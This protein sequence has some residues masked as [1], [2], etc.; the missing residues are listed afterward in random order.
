MPVVGNLLSK[1]K[2]RKVSALLA[3]VG[4]VT[5]LV[6]LHKFYLRQPL[7]GIL[8]VLLFATPIPHVASAIEAFWYLAQEPEN[9]D[10]RFN[11]GVAS[12][13]ALASKDSASIDPNRVGATADALRQLEQL[14]QEGLIS[15]YEFEQKRRQLL[16]DIA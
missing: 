15:E 12:D 13:S 5:P 2:N 9:F 14:R 11:F 16:D 3:L 8:Y 7:W 6:G 1:P 10:R 4:V